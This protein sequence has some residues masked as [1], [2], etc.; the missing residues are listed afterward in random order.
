MGGAEQVVWQTINIFRNCESIFLI[1]N[2]EIASYYNPLLPEDRIL[3]I[4]DIFLHSKKK[5]R[6]IRFLLNNR[7]Y[8]LIP[9]IIRF[10]S[11][12]I[13]DYLRR[14]SIETVHTH[15]D[16]ALYSSLHIKKI[17]RNI[18]LYHTVHSAFGLINDKLLKPFLPISKFDFNNVDKLIFVSKYNYNLYKSKNITINSFKIIYN[19][20]DRVNNEVF[21]RP[22]KTNK[23]FEIL[24]VGGS[25]YVK[26][27]D[28]LIETIDKLSK[29]NFA[30]NFHVVVLGHISKNCEL[31][32]LIKQRGLERYFNLIGFVNPPLHLNYFESADILFM[33]SRSEAFPIAIIEAISLNLPVI[34]HNV[35][36]IPEIIADKMN[37]F[38][39]NNIFQEY[40][41]FIIYLIENYNS[42]LPKV[43][44]YNKKIKRD[45]MAINMCKSLLEIYN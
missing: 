15:L 30:N 2:N 34:T 1:V 23:F 28:I 26:G 36:G 44:D 3:N 17:K 9:F 4:G 27:Y 6:V 22:L 12:K 24:Y 11:S 5:Y 43:K 7:I 38:L 21:N 18:K 31:V 40:C 33:P 20:I 16:Y 13:A 14:Y 41:D 32:T 45:F 42:F 39:G 35:G 19:G 37:G 29:S 25:K 10:K 8:S